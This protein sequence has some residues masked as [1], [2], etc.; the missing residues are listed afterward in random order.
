MSQAIY[1]VYRPKEFKEV[2]GQEHVKITL[3]NQLTNDSVAHA[4]LF[5]GPRGIGKTTLARL[6]AKALNCEN[7]KD[8]QNEPCGACT[9]CKELASGNA[10]DTIEID[11]ASHTGVDNVRE[12]IIESVRFTPSKGKY[13]IF[14]ID[15]VHMLSTS[16]FNALLKTLEEPPAHAVFILATTEIHKIPQT[17]L[18]RC[19]RFDFHRISSENIKARIHGISQKEGVVIDSDVVD[20][21][22]RLSEGCLRDAESLLGQ[23]LALGEKKITKEHASLILPATNIDIVAK[24]IDAVSL[25][26]VNTA[27]TILN[28][29]IGQGG[30]IKSFLDELIDYT[31]ALMMSGLG[32]ADTEVFGEDIRELMGAQISRLNTETNASLLDAILRVKAGPAH[33]KIPQ[34]PLEIGLIGWMHEHGSEKLKNTKN[35]NIAPRSADQVSQVAEKS[36]HS[37]TESEQ[38]KDDSLGKVQAKEGSLSVNSADLTIEEVRSKWGRCCEAVAKRNVALPLA[39]HGAVPDQMSGEEL[40]L[41]FEHRFHF[42]AINQQ[43]NLL[44]LREAVAEVLGKLFVIKPVF[45]KEKE[46]ADLTNL[47]SAFGGTVVE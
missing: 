26:E 4:Y 21:I 19:Q 16:A 20:Q 36:T 6:L 37:V 14:I 47:A 29:F 9:N 39:L 41:S 22:S 7:R 32:G 35:G 43:K 45:A 33:D 5:A 27:I 28:D 8:S 2:T 31:R 38:V 34:L 42:D 13:K 18:S 40:T 12:N 30:K 15:E 23:L 25:N 11:A 24:L 10:L 46:E 3:Q 44:I 1:R 17:I